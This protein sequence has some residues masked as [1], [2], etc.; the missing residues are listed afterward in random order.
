MSPTLEQ[1]L[2][3]LPIV[4]ILRGIW[5]EE[6]DAVADALVAAGIGIVEVP[7]N[8]P[9]ALRSIERLALRIGTQVLV[10]AGTVLTPDQVG[11]V[12]AAGG[13][14]IVSPD[15]SA[16]VIKA[17]LQAGVSVLP[18]CRTATEAFAALRSG[19]RHLKFFPCAAATAFELSALHAVLPPATGLVAV[20]GVDAS[21]MAPLRRAGAT[22]IGIGSAL[23]RPGDE[24]S[25][26]GI[27]AAALVAA[28]HDAACPGRD[29][30]NTCL[31]LRPR[32][33][34]P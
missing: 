11:E 34:V 27:R 31:P 32:T 9:Q 10:G 14:L 22:G 30:Q 7:L 3:R 1:G 6:I 2:A 15:T 12:V 5:P 21:A 13:Q 24:A 33:H 25:L 20:G 18:G 29:D 17:A 23:Y 4:A 26:V 16:S 28:W 8:S 19:A